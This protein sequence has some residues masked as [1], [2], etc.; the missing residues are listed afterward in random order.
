MNTNTTDVYRVFLKPEFSVLESVAK[1]LG[2]NLTIDEET[3]LAEELF[4][5]RPVSP[6]TEVGRTPKEQGYVKQLLSA[7]LEQ[8]KMPPRLHVYL[9][10][11]GYFRNVPETLGSRLFRE[12]KKSFE[13]VI[14]T[15]EHAS[16]V[17]REQLQK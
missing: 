10:D 6:G 14:D 15:L 7:V 5:L 9:T 16:G 4:Q 12:Q 17:L 11:R 2:V 1:D 8:N 13:D 3:Q